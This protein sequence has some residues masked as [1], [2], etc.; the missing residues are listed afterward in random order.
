MKVLICK[1]YV[2][3]ILLSLIVF[4]AHG[5]CQ[6][7]KADSKTED[8]QK[9]EKKTAARNKTIRRVMIRKTRI[10]KIRIKTKKNPQNLE[11]LLYLH[12]N[13]LVLW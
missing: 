3:G 11:I 2:F 1:R 8:S 9:E 10:K 12:L 13:S 5:I 7:E 4:S 6:E